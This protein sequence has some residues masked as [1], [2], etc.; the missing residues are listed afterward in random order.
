[1]KVKHPVKLG[2]CTVLLLLSIPQE[3]RWNLCISLPEK[4]PITSGS[5]QT[6]FHGTIIGTLNLH[7]QQ[8]LN[9]WMI[10]FLK[11]SEER[12]V[13]TGNQYNLPPNLPRN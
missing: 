1:M 13:D 10:L 7:Q 3:A 6:K 8:I 2:I 11:S 12:P 9:Y 4:E 5:K